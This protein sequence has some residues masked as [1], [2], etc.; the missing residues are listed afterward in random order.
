M[1]MTTPKLSIKSKRSFAALAAAIVL[2]A[3]PF[4]AAAGSKIPIDPPQK[5]PTQP[6][7]PP[8]PPAPPPPAPVPPPVVRDHRPPPIVRDH[9]TNVRDHRTPTAPPASGGVTVTSVP[10]KQP[11]PQPGYNPVPGHY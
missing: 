8:P 4:D 6:T 1:T 7:P 10:R 2:L 5:M 11:V 3:A 9:R